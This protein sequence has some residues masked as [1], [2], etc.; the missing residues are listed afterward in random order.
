MWFDVIPVDPSRPLSSPWPLVAYVSTAVLVS[1]GG[2]L[3]G[4][5]HGAPISPI[6][7]ALTTPQMGMEA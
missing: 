4:D 6:T 2:G 3:I 5:I 7:A 1:V